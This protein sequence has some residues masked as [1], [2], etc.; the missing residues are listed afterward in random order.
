LRFGQELP[1]EYWR[2][3]LAEKFG[4]T[5]EYVDGLDLVDVLQIATVLNA[6][7]KAQ[8]RKNK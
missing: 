5:L 6:I 2:I 3:S 8:Q 7:D 4:W 1:W